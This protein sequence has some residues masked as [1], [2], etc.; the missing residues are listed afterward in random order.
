MLVDGKPHT[1]YVAERN[2]EPDTSQAPIAHP[3]LSQVFQTFLNGR[4]YKDNLN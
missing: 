4:Y 3:M 2:L 1:T